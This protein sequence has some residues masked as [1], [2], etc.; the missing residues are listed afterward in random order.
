MV[1]DAVKEDRSCVCVCVC[2][3]ESERESGGGWLVV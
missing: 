3:R 1:K 2:V